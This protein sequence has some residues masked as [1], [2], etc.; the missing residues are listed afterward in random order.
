M[1]GTITLVRLIIALLTLIR[2]SLPLG[3]SQLQD[4]PNVVNRP[5]RSFSSENELFKTNCC[6][7]VAHAFLSRS[8]VTVV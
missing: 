8:A 3:G 5:P 2:S 4:S 7:P 6:V 1:P